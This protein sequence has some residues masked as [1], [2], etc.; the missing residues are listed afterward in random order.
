MPK[1]EHLWVQ[2]AGLCMLVQHDKRVYVLMPSMNHHDHVHCTFLH[3]SKRFT[4][5]DTLLG[6]SHQ[7]IELR[8]CRTALNSPWSTSSKYRR[9]RTSHR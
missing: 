1:L 3:V 9:R 8:W 4:E 6:I 7:A 5:K 2:V